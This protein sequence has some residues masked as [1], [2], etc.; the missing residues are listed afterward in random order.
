ML[1]KANPVRDTFTFSLGGMAAKSSYVITP[2][3]AKDRINSAIDQRLA[4]SSEEHIQE[5]QLDAVR[6]L[7]DILARYFAPGCRDAA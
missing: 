4:K 1:V 3:V 6:Q 2:A 5:D 7:E